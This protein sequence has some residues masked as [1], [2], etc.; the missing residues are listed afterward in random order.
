MCKAQYALSLESLILLLLH[1]IVIIL[2]SNI[3]GVHLKVMMLQCHCMQ[4][5]ADCSGK[6]RV[7]QHAPAQSQCRSTL[8]F[9]KIFILVDLWS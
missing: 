7:W 2:L 3:N 1:P 8:A 5:E 4:M 9:S 6:H